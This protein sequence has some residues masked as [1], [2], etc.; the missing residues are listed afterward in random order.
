MDNCA[1]NIGK[2]ERVIKAKE[3]FNVL[4]PLLSTTGNVSVKL[5]KILFES[6][7]EPIL[8]YGSIIWAS[9]NN[10]NTVLIR[11]FHK[12]YLTITCGNVRNQINNFLGTLWDDYCPQ[13]DLIKTLGKK[14][15]TDRPILIKFTHFHDKEKLL[16]DTAN[17][18]DRIQV[19]DNSKN[20]GCRE[21]E[22]M[23]DINANKLCS[24]MITRT[25]LGKFPIEF[26]VH[27]S[28]VKYFLRLSRGTGNKLVNDAFKCAKDTDSQWV[29]TITRL[30]KING[31]SNVLH[32]PLVVN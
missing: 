6:K 11:G 25:E 18:P 30:L 28:V 2:S 13:L 21:I 8:T 7:I 32:S 14:K 12:K 1:F 15:D 19:Q 26:K 5:A 31:F 3:A 22:L 29:Q 17:V 20:S 4:R 27:T 23:Q 16:F 9:E 10:T 24:A